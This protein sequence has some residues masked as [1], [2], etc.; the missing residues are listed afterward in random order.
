MSRPDAGRF[1]PLLFYA[2][3]IKCRCQYADFEAF[4]EILPFITGFGRVFVF[5]IIPVLLQTR[6]YEA[7]YPIP[8]IR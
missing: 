6:F 3:I 5:I 4:V 8:I 7:F 2:P 1:M